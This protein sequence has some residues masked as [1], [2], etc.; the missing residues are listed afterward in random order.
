MAGVDSP[1]IL[2]PSKFDVARR[3]AKWPM[4]LLVA[5]I[6]FAS[7][8]LFIASPAPSRT[9]GGADNAFLP[10]FFAFAATCLGLWFIDVVPF[11]HPPE[12]IQLTAEGV[13]FTYPDQEI[14]FAGWASP[15][16]QLTLTSRLE[17]DWSR[18]SPGP[19]THS[20]WVSR[21]HEVGL[22]ERVP[23]NLFGSILSQGSLKGLAIHSS[24]STES[25]GRWQGQR[26][27]SEITRYRLRSTRSSDT[28]E[29]VRDPKP[30]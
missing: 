10:I 14:W 2:N 19:A 8:I 15:D 20:Y 9:S 5:A 4:R 24:I 11:R 12:S 22:G 18:G 28:R 3:K 30:P 29:A 1:L 21:P 27:V 16:F 25:E 26:V 6:W 13:R 23:E 7:I 17:H